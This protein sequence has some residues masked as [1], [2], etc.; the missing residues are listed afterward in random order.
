[1]PA[2]RSL[3]RFLMALTALL[4]VVLPAMVGAVPQGT[5][6]SPPAAAVRQAKNVAIISL[7]GPI[8]EKRVMAASVERRIQQ[9]AAAGADAIVFDINTPGGEVGATLQICESIKMS[10]VPNTIAWV[11]TNAISGGA[12]IALAAREMITNDPAVMGDAMPITYDRGGNMR[13]LTPDEVRKL[14]PPLVAQVIDSARRYNRTFGGYIRDEY[15]L[16]AI[17]ATDVKLWWV[18]HRETGQEMAIDRVEWDMLFPGVTPPE[19]PRLAPGG[20]RPSAVART[21]GAVTPGVPSTSEQ[22]A[23]VAGS[24]AT[25]LGTQSS[26]RPVLTAG[27]AGKWESLGAITDGTGAATFNAD[28]MLFYNLSAN[29]VEVGK[30]GPQVKP[31]RTEAD[32]KEFLGAENIIRYDMSWSEHLVEFLTHNV[33]RG[34]LI[35]IFLVSLFIE[36]S[37]PGVVLPGIVALIALAGLLAPPLLIGMA[38]WWEI[39]AILL[40][41]VLLGLEAFVIPGFGVFGVLGCIFLFGGLVATF[42]PGSNVFPDTPQGR[43]D[44]LWGV[45]TIILSVFTAGMAMW[46]IAKHFGSLPMLNRLVLKDTPPDEESPGMLAAMEDVSEVDVRPGDVGFTI[47]PMRP[48]GRVQ[49]KDRVLDAVAE[50]GFI[51]AG[52]SIRVTS[53]DGMRIGVEVSPKPG[54]STEA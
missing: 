37:H 12:I 32:L 41:L 42:V 17:V 14:M 19:L 4:G 44:L 1:M 25:Q 22:L 10:P 39:A 20:R 35:V 46:G 21:Q 26:D 45:T 53:V 29:P 24:V 50:L 27:D 30:G 6:A 23:M 16:Q 8:D 13:G 2:F 52:E 38:A 11:N 15:L 33:V 28:D 48:A 54:G 34:I 43:S 5:T 40:G 51:P 36:M 18:R 31:I 47:T 9:A 7:R 3:S 49:V